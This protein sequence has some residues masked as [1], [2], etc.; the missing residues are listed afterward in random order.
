[1]KLITKSEALEALNNVRR[2]E[3]ERFSITGSADHVGPVSI[4]FVTVWSGEEVDFR[5]VMFV[6][7]N[8]KV[9]VYSGK[10]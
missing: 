6:R 8:G 10:A 5:D 4:F 7:D 2:D 9:K 1:L 3:R